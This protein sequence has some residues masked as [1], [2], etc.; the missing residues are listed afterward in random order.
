MN[1][2]NKSC[3][4]TIAAL[5]L[6]LAASFIILVTQASTTETF[7]VTQTTYQIPFN[8][9]KD[10]IFNGS[11]STTNT[12][13]VWVSD[14]NGSLIANPGLVDNTAIFS[15]VAVKEG[16]YY[17]NFENPLSSSASVTFTYQTDPELQ[18]D[19][20]SLLPFWLLPVFVLVTIVGA[21]LI[22]YFS[23]RKRLQT[24]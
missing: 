20:S 19:N 17:I 10:T 5:T 11:L 8:L 2:V 16:N 23:R 6:L 4:L 9:P 22:V 1:N 13:R 21:I 14:A 3:N 18:S 12:V 15:F 7:T 24:K